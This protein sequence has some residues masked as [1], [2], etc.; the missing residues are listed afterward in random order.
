MMDTRRKLDA[1]L[2]SDE[3]YRAYADSAKELE[4]AYDRIAES[5]PPE[6]RRV[7]VGWKQCRELM[8]LRLKELI[9]QKMVF[10]D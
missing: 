3:I 10:P 5:L 1:L 2:A 7:L 9:C 4:E 8:D 6:D